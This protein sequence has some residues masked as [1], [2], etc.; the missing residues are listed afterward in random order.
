MILFFTKIFFLS[1]KP[2]IF[3][4]LLENQGREIPW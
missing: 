1:E 2:L 4:A 3:A